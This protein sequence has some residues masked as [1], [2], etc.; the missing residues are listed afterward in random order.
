MVRKIVTTIAFVDINDG[1][2]VS[3]YRIVCR[4]QDVETI[5]CGYESR[6]GLHWNYC[7]D[8]NGS[9]VRGYIDVVECID[10]VPKPF[11]AMEM[12]NI[13][14]YMK[15]GKLED[16]KELNE[17]LIDAVAQYIK[18]I[19]P[20]DDH[21]HYILINNAESGVSVCL[22]LPEWMVKRRLYLVRVSKVVETSKFAIYRILDEDIIN[23]FVVSEDNWKFMLL[24]NH[25][26][27]RI[28]I[29]GNGELKMLRLGMRIDKKWLCD[30][31]G[32]GFIVRARDAAVIS[33]ELSEIESIVNSL[34]GTYLVFTFS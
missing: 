21:K 30:T 16:F 9:A 11:T 23:R 28:E 6:S 25:G 17:K 8:T 22:K 12:K 4:R 24:D 27:D 1:K 34:D 5:D 20:E 13:Y 15:S 19:I 31:I 3:R 26:D 14:Q 2:I 7:R 18:A 33:D 10:I 29:A 32:R